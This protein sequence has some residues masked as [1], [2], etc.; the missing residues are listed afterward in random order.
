[1]SLVVQG[2]IPTQIL[3][4]SF[5]SNHGY[6]KLI[7]I[8]DLKANKPFGATHF[9]PINFALCTHGFFLWLTKGRPSQASLVGKRSLVVFQKGGWW[10]SSGTPQIWRH[11]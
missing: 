8:K 10:R 1:M 4:L 5:H 9:F 6:H 3:Y 2:S 7:D 11:W